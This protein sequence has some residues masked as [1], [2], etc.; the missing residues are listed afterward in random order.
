MA[1]RARIPFFL[2]QNVPNSV[3]DVLVARGHDVELLRDNLAT[4]TADPIV[5]QVRQ[6]AGKVLVSH[7]KD[8]KAIAKRVNATQ[9]EYREAL[10]RIALRCDEPDSA[11]R[12]EEAMDFIEHEW[13]VSKKKRTPLNLEIRAQSLCTFR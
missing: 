7:D 11:R 4:D 1:R 6:A 5:A 2:D 3:R 10:H 9:R 12:I 13:A 8:F